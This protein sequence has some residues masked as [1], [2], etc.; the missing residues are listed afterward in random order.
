MKDKVVGILK[1]WKSK[2]NE[3]IETGR[4]FLFGSLINYGGKQFNSKKSDVDLIIEFPS[5]LNGP[6]ETKNWIVILKK[7]KKILEQK[8]SNELSKDSNS[9]EIVSLIPISSMEMNAHIHKS[10]ARNFYKINEFYDVESDLLEKGD[11]LFQYENLNDE[12]VI[13]IFETSQKIRNEY[14]KNSANLDLN[15]LKWSEIDRPIPKDLARHCAKVKSLLDGEIFSADALNTSLGIDFLKAITSAKRDNEEIYQLYCW[16]DNRTNGSSSL[17]DCEILTQEN[18]LLLYEIIYDYVVTLIPNLKKKSQELIKVEFT[19]T[20]KHFISDTG[21]LEKLH[22]HQSSLLLDDIFIGP[23]M[24]FYDKAKNIKKE[25][26]FNELI[27][28]FLTSNKIVISGKNQS[29]KSTL[30]KKIISDLYDLKL[31]P[32]YLSEENDLYLGNVGIKIQK[33]YELQYLESASLESL[34]KDRIVI[35][36]DDFHKAKHKEKFL[37]SLKDYKH[38]II[39]IDDIFGLRYKEERLISNFNTYEICELTPSQR[40][41]LIENWV[42]LS[43]TT[44]K[45]ENEIIKEI[46]FNNDLVDTALGKIIGQGI[47]PSY[48][49]FILSVIIGYESGKPLDK[50]TSQGHFYQSLIILYLQKAGVVDFDPYLNFLIEL[51]YN[52]YSSEYSQISENEFEQFVEDYTNTYNL[53]VPLDTLLKNLRKT[54]ILTLTDLGDYKFSYPYLYYFFVAKYL[55]ENTEEEKDVIINIIDNLHL[56]ENAYISIFITH[57]DKNNFIVEEILGCAKKLFSTFKPSTLTI[58]ELDFFD[59]ETEEIIEASMSLGLSDY[60]TNRRNELI[61]K[62]EIEKEKGL[63]TTKVNDSHTEDEDDFDELDDELGRDLRR[64]VKTVE[65]IGRIIKN[66]ADSLK[67][68]QIEELFEE[69]MNVHLRVLSSFIQLINKTDTQKE[70]IEII[71]KRIQITIKSASESNQK[72]IIHDEEK[73]RKIAKNIFWNINYS[74]IYTI[75]SKIIHSLGSSKL[76][77]NVKTVCDKINT[78]ASLLVK[79]GIFM[80]YDKSLQIDKIYDEKEKLSFSITAE[81]VLKQKIVNHCQTHSFRDQELIRIEDRMKVSKVYLVKR[82]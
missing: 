75:N 28:E 7:H 68:N 72:K 39:V 26:K 16:I 63:S 20:H 48:P 9:Q 55:S 43:D 35:I 81:K 38:Q 8:L 59:E 65:V 67:K 69:G 22:G 15:K 58:D 70:L 71:A 37:D 30:C 31:I 13:Q 24:S 60:D 36:I 61:K 41:E 19:D 3:E 25:I 45:N 1:D 77:N 53:T 74:F 18:H 50:I 47:L 80:R 5:G 57:H 78:P 44:W 49:F 23:N 46:E 51:S 40:Y 42:L 27:D 54:N 66:R 79:H 10:S 32:I 6:I 21:L 4:L 33:A 62:D 73:L 14:L 52:I 12:L 11:V 82:K 2:L 34:D 64:S 17:D 29:G 56:D 76:S